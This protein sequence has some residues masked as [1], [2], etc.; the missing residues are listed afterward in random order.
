MSTVPARVRWRC[1]R[2]TRELDTLLE[3][4]LLDGYRQLSAE[5]A[6]D[7][8]RLLEVEDDVLGDWLLTGRDAP[9]EQRLRYLVE[10]I[11]GG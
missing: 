11:R 10:R 4:F 6:R 5:Q 1:R 8:E 9:D 7:F 2:G 3:R